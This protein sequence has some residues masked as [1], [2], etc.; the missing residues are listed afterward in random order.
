MAEATHDTDPRLSAARQPWQAPT[1][2]VLPVSQTATGV[3]V[4]SDGPAPST[5]S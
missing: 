1:A 3:A 5:G 4:G 2:E